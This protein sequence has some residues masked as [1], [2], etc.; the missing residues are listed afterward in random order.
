MENGSSVQDE[1]KIIWSIQV[2]QLGRIS[3][4]LGVDHWLE[5]VMLRK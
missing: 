3:E 4:D 5:F 2:P 1:M